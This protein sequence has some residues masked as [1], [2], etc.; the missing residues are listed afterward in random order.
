MRTKLQEASR[1]PRR[2]YGS[3]EWLPNSNRI[4]SFFNKVVLYTRQTMENSKISIKLIISDYYL[5]RIRRRRREIFNHLVVGCFED[6]ITFISSPQVFSNTVASHSKQKSNK[7]DFGYD[8]DDSC[9][10]FLSNIYDKNPQAQI[11]FI[12][13]AMNCISAF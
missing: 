3:S 9:Y 2:N 12:H 8:P 10:R 1:H 6:V 5:V 11:S 13:L 7:L 4:F